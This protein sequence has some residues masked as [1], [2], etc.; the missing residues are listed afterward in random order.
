MTVLMVALTFCIASHDLYIVHFG[1]GSQINGPSRK[2]FLVCVCAAAGIHV[3]IGVAINRPRC[4]VICNCAALP[5]GFIQGQVFNWYAMQIK[6]RRSVSYRYHTC[7]NHVPRHSIPRGV[8]YLYVNACVVYCRRQNWIVML[9]R[10]MIYGMY[11]IWVI[12]YRLIL[13]RL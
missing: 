11:N 12:L 2:I 1:H 6:H 10:L 5:C 3:R 8:G 13:L 9:C 4:H 7:T